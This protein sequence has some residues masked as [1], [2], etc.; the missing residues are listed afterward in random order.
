VIL[1]KDKHSVYGQLGGVIA[2]ADTASFEDH[3]APD[4]SPSVYTQ[5]KNHTYAGSIVSGDATVINVDRVTFHVISPTE[6]RDKHQ[7]YFEGNMVSE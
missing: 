4:G 7:L 1:A 3:R 5:D 2:G 6:A